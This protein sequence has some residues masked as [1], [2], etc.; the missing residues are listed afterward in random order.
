MVLPSHS[1]L[2]PSTPV[3]YPTALTFSPEDAHVERTRIHPPAARSSGGQSG[4]EGP[5]RQGGRPARV[6]PA[7]AGGAALGQGGGR[8]PGTAVCQ[9]PGGGTV[10]GAGP[11]PKRQR[12]AVP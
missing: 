7:G 11:A 9:A 1:R 4:P 10:R 5:G 3:H 12:P 8:G 2:V 6:Q